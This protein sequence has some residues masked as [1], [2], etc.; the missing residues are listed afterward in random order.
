MYTRKEFLRNRNEIEGIKMLE[1]SRLFYTDI[2][3]LKVFRMLNPS[4]AVAFDFEN[5][6]NV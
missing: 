2:S 4:I 1:E 5:C 3:I 6:K